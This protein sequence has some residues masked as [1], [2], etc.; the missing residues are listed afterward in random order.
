MNDQPTPLSDDE[1]SAALDGEVDADTQARIDAD[2]E[3]GARTAELAAASELLAGASVPPLDAATVDDLIGTALDAPVAPARPQ[4]AGQR[5]GPA[6]WLVAAGVAVLMAVGLTLIWSGRN[7]EDQ[8][9]SFDNVS[10]EIKSSDSGGAS[11][12][13]GG[14]SDAADAPPDHDPTTTGSTADSGEASASTIPPTSTRTLTAVDL[15]TFADGDALRAELAEGS[16]DG[17]VS[18]EGTVGDGSARSSAP[19]E[20]AFDRCAE[21][22]Q[23]TLKLDDPAIRMGYATVADKPVVVYEF[24]TVSSRTGDPTTLVAA[25]GVDACEQVIIFER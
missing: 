14:G 2:P 4:S 17:W 21:Q 10:A 23:V 16:E 13:S 5:R 19:T 25:V 1:L 8:T 24:P 9:A 22:L 7:D 6:P 15:G 18:S 11:S 20:D 12:G 3:A